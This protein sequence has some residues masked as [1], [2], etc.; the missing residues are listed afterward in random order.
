M[1][2]YEGSPSFEAYLHN[3][4]GYPS[5]FDR[6][7]IRILKRREVELAG[8]DVRDVATEGIVK[9]F[10]DG[11]TPDGP[12]LEETGLRARYDTLAEY[13]SSSEY[14]IACM[15]FLAYSRDPRRIS[16]YTTTDEEVIEL[17]DQSIARAL[18]KEHLG[19]EKTHRLMRGL[20]HFQRVV[21]ELK[22]LR[23]P[24]AGRSPT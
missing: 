21:D 22:Q 3:P 8:V 9:V 6:A 12:T 19:V 20:P 14:G 11:G 10:D 5:V 2:D 24:R 4:W 1:G 18:I 16:S 17:T 13:T 15:V 23:S 7:A